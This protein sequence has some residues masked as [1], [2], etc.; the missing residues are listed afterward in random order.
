MLLKRMKPKS[1]V[2][3]GMFSLVLANTIPWLLRHHSHVS[4]NM[5]DFTQGLLMGLAIGTLILGIVALQRRR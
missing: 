3:I 1:V 5:V 2:A 4:A